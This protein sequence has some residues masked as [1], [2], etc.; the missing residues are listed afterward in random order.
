[1]GCHSSS[2]VCEATPANTYS[3]SKE[4]L[5]MVLNNSDIT[6]ANRNVTSIPANLNTL[7][8]VIVYMCV[9]SGE[10]SSIICIRVAVFSEQHLFL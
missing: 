2:Y 4:A 10:S 1:M 3:V 8:N 7:K 6:Q 5:S 9:L